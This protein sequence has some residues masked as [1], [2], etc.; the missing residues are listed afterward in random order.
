M[1]TMTGSDLR[2]VRLQCGFIDFVQAVFGTVRVDYW[3]DATRK[4]VCSGAHVDVVFGCRTGTLTIY[5]FK[6]KIV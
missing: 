5:L 4:I 1:A 2:V 3:I 6:I